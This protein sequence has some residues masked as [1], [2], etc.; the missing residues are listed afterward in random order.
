M[1]SNQKSFS[2]PSSLS[3]IDGILDNSDNDYQEETSVPKE[4]RLTYKNGYYVWCSAVF[5][6]LRDSTNLQSNMK[7]PQLAKILRC[8]ISESIAI[9]NGNIDCRHIYV[10]GDCVWAIINTPNKVDIDNL[11]NALCQLNALTKVLNK[12]INKKKWQ[13]FSDIKAG[14]GVAYGSTLMIKGGFEGSGLNDIVWIGS[15]VSEAAK[16]SGRA[17]KSS[18]YGILCNYNYYSNLNDDNK[19]MF[20]ALLD[21][22]YGSNYVWTEMLN[23]ANEN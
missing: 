20:T 18:Y 10:E 4:E 21:G 11:T 6:D 15:L 12:K 7:R 3:R 8:F 19:K 2:F 14:I 13:S 16:L 9:L 22:S 1:N 5:I 23:W 17:N